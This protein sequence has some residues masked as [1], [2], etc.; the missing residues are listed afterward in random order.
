TPP[1]TPSITTNGETPATGGGTANTTDPPPADT[2][3][4]GGP[5]W[6]SLAVAA[7]GVAV[8]AAPSADPCDRRNAAAIRNQCNAACT[9]YGG[10]KARKDDGDRLVAERQAALTQAQSTLAVEKAAL[11]AGQAATRQAH[12]DIDAIRN[13]ASN[14]WM[15]KKGF[16]AVGI[17]GAAAATMGT[18]VAGVAYWTKTTA[19]VSAG[20]EAGVLGTMPW[21]RGP[22]YPIDNLPEDLSNADLEGMLA[23]AHAMVDAKAQANE[24]QHNASIA[25]AE[26]AAAQAQSDLAAATAQRDAA[27]TDMDLAQSEWAA[28]RGAWDAAC[29]DPPTCPGIPEGG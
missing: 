17:A 23:Q 5:P 20:A 1:D 12:A 24:A 16:Q 28:A 29:G 26:Q 4:G 22:R 11:A 15:A 18:P 13:T 25:Q 6:L 2:S 3:S 21:S 9:K 27:G 7:A 14:R 8:A 10:A 19:A